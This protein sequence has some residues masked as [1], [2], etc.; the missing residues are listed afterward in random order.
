MAEEN[1]SVNIAANDATSAAVRNIIDSLGS[2]QSSATS[3]ASGVTGAFESINHQ[4]SSVKEGIESFNASIASV[5]SAFAIVGEAAMLGA[6][7]EKISELANKTGEYAHEMELASQKTGMSTDSLQAL[8]YAAGF[9]GVSFENLQ[10]GLKKLAKAMME[11]EGGSQKQIA[12][13]K[14]VGISADDLKNMKI[15]DVM[16]KIA[17]AYSETTDGANKMANAQTLLGKSG[18]N[19]IPLFDMG[20][21]GLKKYSEEAEKAGVIMS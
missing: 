12:A 16:Y 7:G 19:L 10:T 1:I 3:A 6:I 2:L 18:M 9:A 17:D 15:E 21:E 14:Q 11:A 20:S 13:F 8:N 5:G 4:V